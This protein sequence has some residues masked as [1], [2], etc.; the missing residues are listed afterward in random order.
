MTRSLKSKRARKRK[1]IRAEEEEPPP[2]AFTIDSVYAPPAR[3]RP[4]LALRYLVY[5]CS[6]HPPPLTA[7]GPAA[8]ALFDLPL[9]PAAIDHAADALP[10]DLRGT[11]RL[12]SARKFCEPQELLAAA[13]EFATDV[14]RLYAIFHFA[15]RR[16]SLDASF[17]GASLDVVFAQ[18]RCGAQ[19]FTLFMESFIVHLQ[20]TAVGVHHFPC[21]VKDRTLSPLAPPERAA[22]NHLALIAVVDATAFVIDPFLGSGVLTRKGFVRCPDDGYFMRPLADCLA[23]YYDEHLLPSLLMCV[24]FESFVGFAS[25][26]RLD[27]RC[28][29]H[30]RNRFTVEEPFAKLQFSFAERFALPEVR[31]YHTAENVSLSAA[32]YTSVE[33]VES[34]AGRRRIFVIVFFP[35]PG[36]FELAL[37]AP[38]RIWA[39]VIDAKTASPAIPFLYSRTPDCQVIPMHPLTRLTAVDGAAVVVRFAALRNFAR[40]AVRVRRAVHKRL[41]P[42]TSV[43]CE[44]E[45]FPIGYSHDR[46]EILAVASFKDDGHYRID[47]NF[48]N[49]TAVFV[50]VPY[51]FDVSVGTAVSTLS[52]DALVPVGRTFPPFPPNASVQ[53]RPSES[54]IVTMKQ[55]EEVV[56]TVQAGK[57]LAV[58]LRDQ[59]GRLG[60]CLLKDR[61]DKGDVVVHRYILMFPT[62]GRFTFPVFVD[63]MLA[64]EQRYAYIKEHVDLDPNEEASMQSA[65]A[66]RIETLTESKL[67]SDIPEETKAL[68]R[69]WL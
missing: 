32:C 41:E 21:M 60:K 7:V 6:R 62:Y 28:E 10:L 58:N 24:P 22:A 44:F 5:V 1:C 49:E 50:S 12:L 64:F 2:P 16:L 68:V 27:L 33:M 23:D 47:F 63:Q 37:H 54:K 52:P 48:W 18:R 17:D 53:I 45:S 36:Q 38:H 34:F 15:T 42:T 31:L 55:S 9:L 57:R 26:S 11:S 4:D 65:L 13:L 46:V 29:S 43:R 59:D 30:Q 51:F 61:V 69:T 35:F 19:G 39:C 56:L 40:L 25:S 67:I 3:P 8:S 14:E 20:L 66:H